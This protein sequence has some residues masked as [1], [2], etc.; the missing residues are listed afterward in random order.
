M[1]IRFFYDEVKYRLREVKY[2]KDFIAEVI[3]E[4]KHSPGDLSFILTGDNTIREINREFL[5][6]DYFT[7]V[8]AFDYGKGNNTCGEIYIS[9]DTVKK[10]AVN[11]KVSFKNELIRVILHG[12]LHLCGYRDGTEEDALIM[13][14]RENELL[15]RF[16]E[17]KG[18]G[19]QI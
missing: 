11:Y 17:G 1:R 16:L 6:Q 19:I 9:V 15:N 18:S 5:K 4:E 10:N 2:L 3:R 8:I 7:D 12:T 14:E 13:K